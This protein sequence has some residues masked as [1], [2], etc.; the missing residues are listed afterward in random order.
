MDANGYLS[1]HLLI[2]VRELVLLH[3]RVTQMR[4]VRSGVRRERSRR[5]QCSAD[6]SRL[7]ELLLPTPPPPLGLQQH[8]TIR[9]TGSR[10]RRA[11]RHSIRR[12]AA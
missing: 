8:S 9:T 1:L 11:V 4:A 6:R 7:Q 2:L 12:P 10:H 3:S 5:T